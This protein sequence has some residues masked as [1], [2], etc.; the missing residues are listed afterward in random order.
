MLRKFFYGFGF[1]A[2]LGSVLAVAQPASAQQAGDIVPGRYIV[3]FDSNTSPG[4][5]AA[6]L[7]R[8]HG[9]QVRHVY[10]RALNGM[11][12]QF[13]AG[14][15][16]AGILTALRRDP[17]VLSIGADLYAVAV[18]EIVTDGLNRVHGGNYSPGDPNTGAGV[19]VAVFD[20]GLD[21]NHEDLDDNI[22]TDLSVNCLDHLDQDPP[23]CV[24]GGQDDDGHGTF[25]GGIIA[26]ED[27]DRD[28]VGVAPG[29]K[30]IA[31]KVLDANGSGPF[32]DII[33]GLEYV[34]GLGSGAVQVANMS[35]GLYC[36]VCT[37]NSTNT[38]VIAFH[39]AV[40]ALV[41]AGITLVVAAGNDGMDVA[42]YIP[43]SFDSVV[44]VSA[45]VDWDGQPDGDG[46]TFVVTTM[47]RVADDTF[48]K[49]SNYGADVDIIA[50]GLFVT[51]LIW[52]GTTGSGSG[53]S[54]SAPYV[55]GAAALF[56]SDYMANNNGAKPSPATV[57]L[58]LIETGE[59][60][61][62]AGNTFYGDNGGCAEIWP[63]DKDDIAEPL[64]R[65]D[66]VLTTFEPDEPVH[67]VAVS[68]SANPASVED[69]STTII[70]V[71]VT[72]IGNQD[73]TVDVTVVDTSNSNASVGSDTTGI[74]APG[75][76]ETL[77]FDWIA[78]GVGDHIMEATA[79]P[80]AGE[81]STADNTK[82]T[83]VTV[84]SPST[85]V[86]VLSVSAPATVTQGDIVDVMVHVSNVGT[87][88]ESVT[89]TLTDSGGAVVG[90]VGGQQAFII[91][92][93]DQV[94]RTF[95]WDT[96]SAS[97]DTH[98]LT[99]SHDLTDD[100]D[101]NDSAFTMST[102]SVPVVGP[103]VDTIYPNSASTN[104]TTDV[105]IIGSGFDGAT[106][107]FTGGSGPTPVVSNVLVV[108]GTTITATVT[109]KKGGPNRDRVW[110]VVVT[111]FDGSSDTLSPGFTVVMP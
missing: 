24:P 67:D 36:S 82:T 8:A 87:T 17:R 78:A 109:V 90:T 39:S 84:Q 93:G 79:S 5:A 33:A 89:V 60:H 26:A 86:A 2:L 19:T 95:T 103:T 91:L 71:T 98:T 81:T 44:T 102:V 77:N 7:G 35:L 40:D 28:I 106:V 66:N 52:G 85:D 30:L 54:F 45:M 27:N 96:T 37:D 47:G 42:N 62:G 57:Q 13:P 105:T 31:V 59:C 88:H 11:A 74:L 4:A 22:L 16:E 72:N 65:A 73:E 68:V 48:V 51:S 110:N 99:A 70:S 34:I 94:T 111:N 9:F 3:I 6:D 25:V 55:A 18:A 32:T 23:G 53:T 63:K 14:A 107:A 56:V 20:S 10:S 75:G 50:P 38:T 46:G 92:A 43:G 83:T 101:S 41:A 104:S 97:T 12:I 21:F 69:G 29:A 64:V 49:F 108:D 100:D 61:E 58:A 80:V 76:F 15:A 1:A